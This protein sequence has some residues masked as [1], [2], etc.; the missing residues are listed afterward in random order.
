MFMYA[1][2][3]ASLRLGLR[4]SF[5]PQLAIVQANRSDCALTDAENRTTVGGNKK[6]RAPSCAA[7]AKTIPTRTLG[8]TTA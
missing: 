2:I 4:V 7:R 6:G 3:C 1:F 8:F 5:Y